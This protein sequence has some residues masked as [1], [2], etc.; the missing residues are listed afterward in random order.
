MTVIGSRR[1]RH[2]S[3]H[4]EEA[5]VQDIAIGTGTTTT[6]VCTGAEG[7]GSRTN[8]T[9]KSGNLEPRSRVGVDGKLLRGDIKGEGDSG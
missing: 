5:F 8:T 1:S 3:D 4:S 2:L 9:R 6:G 7:L